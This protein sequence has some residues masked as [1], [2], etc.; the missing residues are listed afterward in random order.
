V[1]FVHGF[2]AVRK[3]GENGEI[4]VGMPYASRALVMIL[5]AGHA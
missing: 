5:R 4:T 2:N 3:T 1:S